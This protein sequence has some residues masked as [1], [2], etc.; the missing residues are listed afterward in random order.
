MFFFGAIG[1]L[2]GV[3]IA[4]ISLVTGTSLIDPMLAG[5]DVVQILMLLPVVTIGEEILYRRVIQNESEKIVPP[6]LSIIVTSILYAVVFFPLG[7]LPVFIGYMISLT[8]GVLY[9]FS[10]RIVL[11]SIT[12]LCMKVGFLAGLLIFHGG[13]VVR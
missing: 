1:A 2:L 8:M 12:S 7:P 3:V 10:R 4:N 6:F 11:T 5:M 13:L 9:L